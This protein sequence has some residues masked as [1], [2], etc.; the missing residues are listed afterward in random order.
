VDNE[1][2]PRGP[3]VGHQRHAQN[4][5]LDPEPTPQIAVRSGGF[6]EGTEPL[7]R[8]LLTDVIDAAI[9]ADNMA[10][11]RA[12]VIVSEQ[13]TQ[14]L[15]VEDEQRTALLVEKGPQPP[16]ISD[17]PSVYNRRSGERASKVGS[18]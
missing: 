16:K 2:C 3:F 1:L 7:Q 9:A 6:H 8:V 13:P 15:I 12:L 11:F 10:V 17:R 14:T 18:D 5:V 4:P